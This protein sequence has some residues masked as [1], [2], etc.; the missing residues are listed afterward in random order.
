MECFTASAAFKRWSVSAH[1]TS[2]TIEIEHP[3]RMVDL[4]KLQRIP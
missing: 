2:G 1:P 4:V 3:Q